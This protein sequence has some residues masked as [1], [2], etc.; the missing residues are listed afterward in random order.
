[1]KFLSKM[2]LNFLIVIY[3]VFATEDIV[4][5]LKSC[6]I[7]ASTTRLYD[8]LTNQFTE[9]FMGKYDRF[10]G[11]IGTCC[12]KNHE[13]YISFRGSQGLQ[14]PWQMACNRKIQLNDYDIFGEVHRNAYET[15]KKYESTM[16]NCIELY[17]EEESISLKN[18]TVEGYSRG[19]AFA[20]LAAA[21]VKYNFDCPSFNVLCYSPVSMFD[22]NAAYDYNKLI[23][24]KN[25]INFIAREDLIPPF[26]TG[27]RSSNR[28]IDAFVYPFKCNF[29]P[30]GTDIIFSAT[31]S[32]LYAQSVKTGVYPNLD[33]RFRRVMPWL[34][35]AET[36]NA[37]MPELY[38]EMSPKS[39]ELEK[40]KSTDITSF[41]PL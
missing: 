40:Q 37:H 29:T 22:E 8:R 6:D 20:A 14:E 28:I 10:L 5:R 24:N 36:W 16:L 38:N 23:G 26:F 33:S 9:E 21:S 1:M 12:F 7:K 41:S 39:F 35:S 32:A 25:H 11:D 19:T 4:N 2:I 13:A 27:Q 30:I 18:I 17:C 34:L 31:D 3:S 15:F